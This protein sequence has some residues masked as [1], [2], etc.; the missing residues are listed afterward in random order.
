MIRTRFVLRS[1]FDGYTVEAYD[2]GCDADGDM[3]QETFRLWC[4]AREM[5]TTTAGLELPVW[6]LAEEPDGSPEHITH[7]VREALTVNDDGHVKWRRE[8][9]AW[10]AE[11]TK[12][13]RARQAARE[14]A[15]ARLRMQAGV[16]VTSLLGQIVGA[17]PATAGKG[18]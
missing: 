3:Y 10:T 11:R 6:V 15:D 14:Q 4:M 13:E 1:I 18:A 12:Q 5:F 2:E 8:S 17:M 7:K 16:Q 9:K